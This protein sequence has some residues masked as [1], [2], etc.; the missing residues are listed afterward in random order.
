MKKFKRI[1]DLK[2]F[3]SSTDVFISLASLEEGQNLTK[4]NIIFKDEELIKI[5]NRK[6]DHNNG[7]LCNQAGK[8]ICPLHGWEFNPE[9]GSYENIQLVKKEEEFVVEGDFITVK[10]DKYIPELPSVNENLSIKVELLSHACL[11]FVTDDFSFATDPWI[12]GFAFS[13]GWWPS[14]KAPKNWVKS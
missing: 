13:S 6:C 7:R 1:G 2:Y 14:Q 11:L 10:N 5:F 4:D 3:I 12:E 8:I 9:T